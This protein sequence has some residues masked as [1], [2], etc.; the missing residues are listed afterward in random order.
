MSISRRQFCEWLTI[1]GGLLGGV[2]LRA[3]DLAGINSSALTNSQ[4]ATGSHLGNLYP[5]VQKQ[6]DRSPLE[7]SFLRSEFTNLKRWQRRA[8]A[9]VF[10]HLFYAPPPVAPQANLIRRT[11][12]GDYI[13]EYL[14]FQTTP[15]LR[16]PAYVLLP[17]RAKL[18]A[19]GVVV[20]HSHDGRYLW[21]KEKVVESE[22]EHPALTEFKQWRYGGKSIAAELARLGYVTIAIDMF[23]W[24]ERRM[25]LDDD[26]PHVRDRPLSMTREEIDAFNQRASENESL[27]ARSL[28][29]AG[30]S[31]PGVILWDDIRT[32]DYLASRPEVD[33]N[34]LGCVGLSVGGYRSFLLAALD[35]R[36]KAAVDVGW[37]TSFAA[38]IK[39]HVRSSI[40][41]TF[42]IPGLYRYLDLP[43][44]AALIAPRAALVI[45]GSQDRLFA[46]DGVKAAFDK[47]GRCYAK[48]GV[49][50]RQ[51]CRLY[52]APHEFN[53]EMQAEAW[54]WFKR[55][56]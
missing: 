40:G 52:D 18:P 35:E 33:R 37:M 8:R 34:R 10:E 22:P 15:D 32:L 30:V 11:D 19:P 53:L 38:Q 25:I 54:E 1:A 56:V 17:K 6:A 43:D 26:P 49:I 12:K 27:V 31:W 55:W 4:A 48:A 39:R 28:F 20:L 29:T 51:R 46:L 24:G 2:E 13:E 14:T 45:N 47:I 50:E 36:I 16:V 21:G 7:L 3:E 23:Y 5:F 42:H 44:L 41:L 9:K